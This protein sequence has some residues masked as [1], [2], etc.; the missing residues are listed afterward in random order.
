LQNEFISI[1]FSYIH[2][3]R[4]FSLPIEF[5]QDSN[6]LYQDADLNIDSHK[7]PIIVKPIVPGRFPPGDT[8]PIANEVVEPGSFSNS[9]GGKNEMILYTID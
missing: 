7:T 5:E 6:L 9:I 1:P 8:K 2:F 4:N 3:E